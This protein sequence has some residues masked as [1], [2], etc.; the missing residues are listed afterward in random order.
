MPLTAALD[1]FG[2]FAT[3]LDVAHPEASKR[4]APTIQALRIGP[5]HTRR[6]HRDFGCSRG[7]PVQPINALNSANDC[8][9]T[10]RSHAPLAGAVGRRRGVGSSV[11]DVLAV[12]VFV[13][14]RLVESFDDT[15]GDRRIAAVLYC[16]TESVL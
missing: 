4:P 8:V 10:S 1:G 12:D 11:A 9:S 7:R 15:V 14:H 5:P 3:T 6:S 16:T 2:A 13:F